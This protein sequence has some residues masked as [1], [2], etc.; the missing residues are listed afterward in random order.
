MLQERAKSVNYSIYSFHSMPYI[1]YKRLYS[2]NI[3]LH[4]HLQFIYHIFKLAIFEFKV[5]VNY[6]LRKSIVKEKPKP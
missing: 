2:K 5:M 6:G 3:H 1:K 4:L